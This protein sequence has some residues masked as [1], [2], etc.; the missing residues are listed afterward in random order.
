MFVV[1]IMGWTRRCIFSSVQLSPLA[2]QQ[3]SAKAVTA[4]TATKATKAGNKGDDDNERCMNNGGALYSLPCLRDLNFAK[5]D[6]FCERRLAKLRTQKNIRA[7][8]WRGANFQGA[9][10]G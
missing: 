1:F 4:V 10:H 6:Q 9:S 2:P 5:V 3:G 8:F 7:Q